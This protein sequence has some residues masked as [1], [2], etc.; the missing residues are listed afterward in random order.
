MTMPAKAKSAP[1]A[2]PRTI[3]MKVNGKTYAA[4]AEP[5]MSL[6]DFLREHARTTGVRTNCEHGVCGSCTVLLNG[7]AVRSCLTLAVQAEGQEIITIEG[8][9][10]GSELHPIQQAYWEE[11]GLQCGFCTPGTIMSLY[12]LLSNNPD[13]SDAE[14]Y[15]TLGGHTCR[16][17]GYKQIFNSVKRASELLRGM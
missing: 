2:S 13:P 10:K 9:A 1:D 17:T 12:E 6:T 11:H 8:L 16:C 14:I 5:R 7:K 15:D 4:P 3:T